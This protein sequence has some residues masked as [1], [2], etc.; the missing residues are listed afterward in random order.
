MPLSLIE[1]VSSAL[2]AL[3]AVPLIGRAWA[4]VLS[5]RYR[6]AVAQA[7]STAPFERR[8]GMVFTG[9]LSA[10]IGFGIPIGLIVWLLG[11]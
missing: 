4:F 5:A 10:A 1:A 9:V 6:L 8:L 11:G 2:E 3:E 7:W